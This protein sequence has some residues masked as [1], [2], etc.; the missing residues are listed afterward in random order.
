MTDEVKLFGT[1]GSTFSRRV[2]IALKLKGVSYEL[3]EEDLSNKS[4]QLLKYNPVHKEIP[5]LHHNGKPIAASLVILEYIDETWEGYPILP[6]VPHE[7]ARARFW[8]KF[9][10]VKCL[11]A[12][13][14][15]C[16]GEGDKK[17]KMS[18]GEQ[19]KAV[20][21]SLEGL[22]TLES[23]LE[24]KRFFGGDGIGL[25]DIAASFIAFWLGAIQELVRWSC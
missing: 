5:V 1:W 24:G 7:R 25:V 3:I 11:I 16:W 18:A 8:A 6:Q 15:A 21:E 2:E 20:E 22:K 19:K 9:M 17:Q 12:P 23:A 14:I 10:D 13:W 4:P